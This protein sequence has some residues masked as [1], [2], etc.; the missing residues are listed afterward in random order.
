MEHPEQLQ[1][2]LW[3]IMSQELKP[4]MSEEEIHFDLLAMEVIK[5]VEDS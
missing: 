5:L 2:L 4:S 3:H 1:E